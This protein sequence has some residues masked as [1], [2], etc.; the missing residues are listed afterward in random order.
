MN[1]YIKVLSR[2]FCSWKPKI[3]R[4][5]NIIDKGSYRL[6]HH[7]WNAKEAENIEIT[8]VQPKGV[9]DWI[10]YS[11]VKMARLSF[12]LVSGYN[13]EK[14]NETK[15]LRRIIFLETVAGV[16]GMV[17][18]MMRHM[19]S[20]RKMESDGGWIISLLREAENERMHLFT[21]I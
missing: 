16:P 6:A 13:P 15:Y 11:I 18:G 9:R 21:F 12:D 5:K 1:T 8:H 2:G 19:R 3:P 10:A 17:A 14:M 4:Y 7:I 20:L